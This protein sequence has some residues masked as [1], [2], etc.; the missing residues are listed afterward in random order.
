MSPRPGV[1]VESSVLDGAPIRAI[2]RA[3]T[4]VGQRLRHL[5]ER[6]RLDRRTALMHLDCLLDE[7]PELGRALDVA[8][9]L[10]EWLNE[11]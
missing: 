3:R 5:D 6:A 11:T 9:E 10:G 2:P 7:H 8:R 4:R 1:I